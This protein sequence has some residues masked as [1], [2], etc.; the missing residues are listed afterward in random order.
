MPATHILELVFTLL[1]GHAIGDF[2]L[3]TEWVATN[4]NRHVRLRFPPEQRA[5]METI[6]PWLLSAH[7]LIQG[8]IVFLI[9]QRLSL[10]IAET[11]VHWITDFGKCEKWYGFQTDQIIHVATK[12]VWVALIFYQVV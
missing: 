1:A 6:W 10:G 3:Q 12:L 4:K 2:A 8:G 5:Q 11:L 7:A 9:T